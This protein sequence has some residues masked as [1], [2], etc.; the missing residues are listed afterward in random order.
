MVLVLH[1]VWLDVMGVFYFINIGQYADSGASAVTVCI[2]AAAAAVVVSFLLWMMM[3]H[4]RTSLFCML[5][6]LT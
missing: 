5:Y 1:A 6:G 3:R 2:G 4:L